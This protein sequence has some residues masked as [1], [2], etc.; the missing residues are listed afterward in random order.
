MNKLKSEKSA[1]LKQHEN[2]PVHWLPF[3]PEAIDQAKKENKPIFLS[4]G[5]SACHWCHVMAH[6]SFED[7]NVAKLLNENFIS[8][9][10]DREEYPDLDSYYQKA[11]QRFSSNGGWPLSAFL[12]PNLKA[13]F[14]ATYFPKP[15]FLEILNKIISAFREKRE[16][17]E[18]DA[19]NIFDSILNSEKGETYKGNFPPPMAIFQA[20]E[21]F[22]DNIDGGYGQAPKFPNFSFLEWSL[23]QMMEA[24]VDKKF[25]DHIIKTIEYMLFGGIYDHARGG[26]HRY[27]VHS[28][29]LI[30][31]FEKM[32]YDQS[33]LIRVLSK[34]GLVNSNPLVFDALFDTLEYLSKEMQS[35]TGSFFASQDADTEGE[36][37]IYFTFSE[38]EFEDLLEKDESLKKQ[39][40][41]LKNWFG[42]LPDGNFEHGQNV[43]SLEPE[44][45]DEFLTDE[46]WEIVRKVRK[47]ILNE[48]R[49]R[50]PPGTDTKGVASWNFMLLASLCDVIQYCPIP[51]IK[52]RAQ[53]LLNKGVKG[54]FD[55]FI[56]KGR[57]DEVGT[58]IRHTT[59]KEETVPYFEDY[60]FFAEAQLRLWEITGNPDFKSNFFD[61]IQ[62]IY[63]Q[64]VENGRA[65]TRAISFKSTDL[66][67][68]LDIGAF[69]SSFKSP[70][71]TLITLTRRAEVLFSK[72]DFSKDF[73]SLV[74][75]VT[76]E[77]LRFPIAA[78]EALRALTYPDQAFRVLKVP[79]KWLDNQGFINFI[80]HFTPR[81][82]I[83]YQEEDNQ[84]W[85]ICT[86][87]S[88]E[89]QG[90]G[91]ENFIATLAPPKETIQ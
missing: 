24:K 21:Q 53:E 8:I 48:R 2:N 55:A 9:K 72:R 59:T 70:L 6:E 67:P 79:K 91:L 68:N 15:S 16:N 84:N 52:A 29:W 33:G 12:L 54:S 46:G 86:I 19:Q 11:C 5:Y 32:L 40:E 31:H 66:Y 23:E 49:E 35:E 22:Q 45:R 26:I 65:K 18:N 28:D 76:G 4:I 80:P 75:F 82:V 13:F 58:A 88:C 51:P 27:S 83:D 87:N 81:F 10:V 74:E 41:K 3:G 77:S 71:S 78:G 64:F 14:V 37:G 69:E 42:I 73:E 1:Y 39:K 89:S 85:Q 20:L 34:L 17:L 25:A 47:E 61:S 90:E 56:I 38:K 7:E 50:I 62:F 63:S 43:I 36:E 44:F 57:E 60:V 30:P